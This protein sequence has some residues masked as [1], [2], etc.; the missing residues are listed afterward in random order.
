MEAIRS[1]SEVEN[2]SQ[3]YIIDSENEYVD[4]MN[5]TGEEVVDY[6]QIS[7]KLN[8]VTEEKYNIEEYPIE[9]DYDGDDQSL[10]E[11]QSSD[12][13]D[14]YSEE[15]QSSSDDD[16]YDSGET[17]QTEYESV[18]E[19]DEYGH[20][21][22]QT[23]RESE[24]KHRINPLYMNQQREINNDVRTT[25]MNWLIA[26]GHEYDVESETM[27][28]TASYIDRFLA[29]ISV[30]NVK[31][32]VIGI[33][34]FYIAAKFE[35]TSPPEVHDLVELGDNTFTVQQ[36]LE[37][38]QLMLPLLNFNLCVPTP[39]AFLSAFYMAGNTTDETKYMA[40][41]I[42][43][44]AML[45]GEP[46]LVY[47]PSEIAAAS[48]ALAR[49]IMHEPIW[50]NEL[51]AL[52]EYSVNQLRTLIMMLAESHAECG[53]HLVKSLYTKYSHRDY[54]SVAMHPTIDMDEVIIARAIH[55]NNVMHL[56]YN[57]HGDRIHHIMEKLVFN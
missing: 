49:F 2:I 48:L 25:L 22:L 16:S 10:N 51:E 52:T 33:T 55:L 1:T 57:N 14:Q 53:T 3:A 27:H 19:F 37:M 54:M 13:E 11:L 20:D 26:V 15:E 6:V 8:Y 35:E 43:E 32:Q 18:D 31:M 41:Y 34:A 21:I 12:D 38:E 17:H 50:S 45:E 56:P 5:V 47:L 40:Q 4:I 42:A 7:D 46:Y 29:V 30:S 39:Y 28:L 44:I 23:L 24:V 36:V 9:E